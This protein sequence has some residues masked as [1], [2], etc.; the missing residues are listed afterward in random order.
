MPGENHIY[1]VALFNTS[2]AAL[3]AERILLKNKLLV[4][5]IPTPREFSS[6]CGIALR[7]NW[8]QSEQVQELLESGHV[9]L[10]SVHPLSN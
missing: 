2:S 5:L 3:R 8:N 6:D 7:F 9:E 1:G 10:A 4:K